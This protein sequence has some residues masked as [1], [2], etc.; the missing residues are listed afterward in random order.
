MSKTNRNK[1]PEQKIKVEPGTEGQN[2]Y[3]PGEG[4]QE[5]GTIEDGKET[6]HIPIV[7]SMQEPSKES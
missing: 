5:A 6:I 7:D 3:Y 2:P 4:A 1:K